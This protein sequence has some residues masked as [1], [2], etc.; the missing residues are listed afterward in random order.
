MLKSAKDL[1]GR[2]GVK[3]HFIK[4]LGYIMGIISRK[5]LSSDRSHNLGYETLR[6]ARCGKTA[7]RV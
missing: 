7:R 2:D 1:D 5:C 4:P 6:K 3:R